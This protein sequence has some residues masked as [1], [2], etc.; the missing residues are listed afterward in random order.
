MKGNR[1]RGGRGGVAQ[2]KGKKATEEEVVRAREGRASDERERRKKDRHEMGE[3]FREVAKGHRAREKGRAS[4]SEDKA[5]ETAK[6][7]RHKA[8]HKQVERQQERAEIQ[9]AGI[10]IQRH[11]V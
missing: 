9:R 5:G 11:S 1:R 3:S 7:K 10:R 8:G 6:G 2:L 4:G